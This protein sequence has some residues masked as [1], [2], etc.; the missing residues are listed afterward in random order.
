M[1]FYPK[2]YAG[3]DPQSIKEKT[4]AKAREYGAVEYL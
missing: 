4:K 2:Q 3:N 1:F